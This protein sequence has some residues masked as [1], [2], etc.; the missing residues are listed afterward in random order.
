[1]NK[2][3]KAVTGLDR[4]YSGVLRMN[5]TKNQAVTGIDGCSLPYDE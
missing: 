2:A 3:T 1:M 5:K 4:C